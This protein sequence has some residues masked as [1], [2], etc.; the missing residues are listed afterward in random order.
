MIKPSDCA[1]KVMDP[2]RCG[3]GPLGCPSWYPVHDQ[4]MIV[5]ESV[6]MQCNVKNSDPSAIDEAIQF[7]GMSFALFDAC[8][9]FPDFP[10]SIGGLDGRVA[11]S[12]MAQMAINIPV[13]L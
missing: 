3:R 10:S 8:F 2:C 12:R 7:R 9:D 13:L 1:N 4:A 11:N 6:N 5:L